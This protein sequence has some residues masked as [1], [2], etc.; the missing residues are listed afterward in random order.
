MPRLRRWDVAVQASLFTGAID[1]EP[2]DPTQF[3]GEDPQQSH[4]Q[5]RTTV[6]L[7]RRLIDEDAWPGLPPETHG[8]RPSMLNA[9]VTLRHDVAI[10]GLSAYQNMRGGVELRAKA[11]VTG[12]RDTAVLMSV[13]YDNQYFYT[14]GKDLHVFHLD[15]RMGW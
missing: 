10:R 6:V 8:V 11:F 15:M 12:L 14:I 13:G 5:Y 9:V 1:I 3:T 4:A 7:L 2:H